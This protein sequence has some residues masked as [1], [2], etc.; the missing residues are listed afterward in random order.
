[1]IEHILGIPTEQVLALPSVRL[2]GDRKVEVCNYKGLISVC[3]TRICIATRAGVLVI[4][5]THLEVAQIA[6]EYLTVR[7][8]IRRI[9][10]EE[11]P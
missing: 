9:Y 4:E 7:G 5:G 1:M 8:M 10:Y 11:M 6:R 2:V 3:D